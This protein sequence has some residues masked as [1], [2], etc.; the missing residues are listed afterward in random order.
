MGLLS[1]AVG[2][3]TGVAKKALGSDLAGPII[4]GAFGLLGSGQAAG[5]SADGSQAGIDE[6]RRQ[7]DTTIGLQ[8]PGINAG[9]AARSQLASILGLTLPESKFTAGGQ[10]F[11]SPGS[12]PLSGADL[13]GLLEKFPGY[14]FAVNEARKNAGAL[15]SATGS[16]GGNVLSALADR[17]AG[18]IAMPTFNSY[19]DRLSGMSV[20]G[21]TSS[22]IASNAAMNTGV[23]IANSLQNAGDARA[24]G[25]LG[26]TS[27]IGGI[28]NGIG[29]VLANRKT[30][31]TVTSN[32]GNAAPWANPTDNSKL[33]WLLGN[34][35]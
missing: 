4:S 29:G 15:G 12:S 9:N 5:A 14:Q 17:T 33:P 18:G 16:L 3:V 28:L 2:A 20:G 8:A 21:Q 22:G 11:T 34:G 35:P 26:Q 30:V 13:Q 32:T 31:P 25:L 19:L 27:T 10:T 23:G 24:S 1:K 7:F 6:Q